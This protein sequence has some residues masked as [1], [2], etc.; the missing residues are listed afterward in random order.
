[1]VYRTVPSPDQVRFLASPTAM[2]LKLST[3]NATAWTWI[4]KTRAAA[5]SERRAIEKNMVNECV[6]E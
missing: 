2:P 3:V 1:M 5:V 6:K 4:G